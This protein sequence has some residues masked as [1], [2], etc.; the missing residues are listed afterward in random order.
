MG[1]YVSRHSRITLS[2]L[3]VKNGVRN[4]LRKEEVVSIVLE[5][6]HSGVKKDSVYSQSGAH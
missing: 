6:G 2:V 1:R 5:A 3:R 4:I